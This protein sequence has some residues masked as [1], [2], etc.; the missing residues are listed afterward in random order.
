MSIGSYWLV[1]LLDYRNPRLNDWDSAWH[2]RKISVQIPLGLNNLLAAIETIV[3]AAFLLFLY[4][5]SNLAPKKY[6]ALN[7]LFQISLLTTLYGSIAFISG[8]AMRS[9]HIDQKAP[10]WELH[11]DEN[12][13]HTPSK[14]RKGARELAKL[15]HEDDK[16]DR[17]LTQRLLNMDRPFYGLTYYHQTGKRNP[18]K[19]LKSTFQSYLTVARKEKL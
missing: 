14:I 10:I 16:D 3:Y 19:E 18:Q 8:L 11:L 9:I 17:A 12:V 15:I 4:P 2:I 7:H 13:T 5:V 1:K 6:S